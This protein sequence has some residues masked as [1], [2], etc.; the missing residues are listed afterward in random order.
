M[1]TTVFKSYCDVKKKSRLGPAFNPACPLL[2]LSFVLTN[3]I[4]DIIYR[5]SKFQGSEVQNWATLNPE[6]RT[7][8][9][10]P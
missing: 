3:D 5:G 7:Q 9:P 4:Y 6:P 8:N 10:E 1:F 2:L